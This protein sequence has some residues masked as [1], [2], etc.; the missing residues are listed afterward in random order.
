ML[1]SDQ[2]PLQL[3]V[4]QL[5]LVYLLLLRQELLLEELV[6]LW[7]QEVQVLHVLT[8]CGCTGNLLRLLNHWSLLRTLQV[9]INSLILFYILSVTVLNP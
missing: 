1:R 7:R 4:G 8:I 2:L 9:V 5:Q 3:G 6:L